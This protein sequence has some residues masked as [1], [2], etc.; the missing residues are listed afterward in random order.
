MRYGAK[1][2]RRRA[3]DGSSG[4]AS[5][6]RLIPAPLPEAQT[7][8]IRALAVRIFQLFECSGVARLDFMIETEGERAG[9]VVFNEINTIPGSLS[10]YLWEPSG[11][12]FDALTERLVEIALARQRDARSRVQSFSVN[13]LS[14]KS[15]GGLKGAKGR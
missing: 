7:A 11:V 1:S 3:A 13:L 14:A 2:P 4:M 9:R 6:D 8:E 5:L 15:L 10:F 12:P